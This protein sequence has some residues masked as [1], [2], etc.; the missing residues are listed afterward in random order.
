[1]KVGFSTGMTFSLEEGIDGIAKAT[2]TFEIKM[3][4]ETTE[5]YSNTESKTMTVTDTTEAITLN[6]GDCVHV[7]EVL[8]TLSYN[9]KYSV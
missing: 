4:M 6:P 2:E 7:K 3:D 5:S 1:V 8:T 9:A